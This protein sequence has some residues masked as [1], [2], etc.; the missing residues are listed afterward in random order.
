MFNRNRKV[1]KNTQQ[2]I[3][4]VLQYVTMLSE[5]SHFPDLTT[6]TDIFERFNPT[7]MTRVELGENTNRGDPWAIYESI[8]IPLTDLKEDGYILTEY[9]TI[10]RA[11]TCIQLKVA[12]TPDQPRGGVFLLYGAIWRWLLHLWQSLSGFLI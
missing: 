6:I 2:E 1:E 12:E 5:N 7:L 3:T 9:I 11:G 10:C 4:I 8:T